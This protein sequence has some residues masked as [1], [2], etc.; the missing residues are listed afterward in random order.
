MKTFWTS[1]LALGFLVNASQMVWAAGSLDASSKGLFV[2]TLPSGEVNVLEEGDSLPILAKNS[3]L[4]VFDGIAKL[5]VDG[6]DQVKLAC[7]ENDVQ[8]TDGQVA[9]LAC[10]ETDGKLK[11]IKGDLIISLK[12]GE[13]VTLKEGEEYSF[14]GEATLSAAETQAPETGAAS[15]LIGGTPGNSSDL[16][17]PPT[18][19]SRS[20]DAS[21]AQ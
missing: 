17:N 7:L 1:I 21:P 13:Q 14:A 10:S 4:E 5:T 8:V 20:I 11:A 16:A 2:V 12:N 9:E 6:G 19:D 15:D 3:K 18:V